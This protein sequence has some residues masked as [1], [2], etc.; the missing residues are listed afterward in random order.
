MTEWELALAYSKGGAILNESLSNRGRLLV[1]GLWQGIVNAFNSTGQAIGKGA[2]AILKTTGEELAAAGKCLMSLLEKI[3]GGKDA[4]EFLKDFTTESANK[5]KGYVS[6]AAKE[7]GSFLI[8]NR[9]KILGAVFEV[10]STDTGVMA[11][12]KELIEKGKKDFG[13]Q[14]DKV[15]EFFNDFKSNP[16]KA[17]KSF[18]NLRKILGSIIA[19]VV[20]MILKNNK[21]VAKKIVGVFDSAGFT[22]SKL[23]MFFLNVLSF[24]STDMGGEEVLEAAGK[25]WTSAKKLVSDKIDLE[26]RGRVLLEMIPKIVKGLVGGGSSLEAVIR[27]ATGD[28]QAMTDLFTNATKMIRKALEKLIGSGAEKAV[29][30]AGFDPKSMLGK[31]VVSAMKGLVGEEE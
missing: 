27:S 16:A 2:K 13:D 3:P 8:D 21:T 24:F 25:M 17:A 10:G 12:L 15:K 29:Q 20:G 1:E 22:K 19:G 11:K 4:F 7:F 28:P 9:D 6:E 23:G 31:T 5:V 14:V 30:A 18:F 26:N